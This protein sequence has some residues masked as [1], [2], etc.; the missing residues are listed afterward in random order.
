ML[1][2]VKISPRTASPVSPE[3]EGDRSAPYKLDMHMRDHVSPAAPLKIY[4][5]WTTDPR[6]GNAPQPP[7]R[8]ADLRSSHEER[9]IA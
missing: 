1:V 4:P 2:A 8:M 5:R 3:L 6:D 9:P 7:V